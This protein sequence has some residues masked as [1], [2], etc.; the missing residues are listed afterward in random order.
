[1]IEDLLGGFDG[2]AGD[3]ATLVDR[4]FGVVSYDEDV[5]IGS[6]THLLILMEWG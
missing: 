4:Q 5:T 2:Y 6:N 3:A 1:M